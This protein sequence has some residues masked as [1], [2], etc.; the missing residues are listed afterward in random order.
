MTIRA[1][2][3]TGLYDENEQVAVFGEDVNNT[4]LRFAG[5][6]T[7]LPADLLESEIFLISAMGESR[8]DQYHLNKYG[9]LEL[10]VLD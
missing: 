7:N 6:L 10:W 3:E 4:A 9:W 8:R 5:T 2:L 1:L